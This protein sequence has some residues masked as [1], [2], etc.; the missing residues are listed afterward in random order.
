[1][2]ICILGMKGNFNKNLGQGVQIYNYQIWNN[3]KHKLKPPSHI[4][5]AELGF[6]NTLTIRKITFTLAQA[7]HNFSKYD[8][9]H[10]PSPIMFNPPGRGQ[11]VTTLHELFLLEKNHPLRNYGKPNIK[12]HNPLTEFIGESI[13]NQI[14]GSDYLLPNS[15][16]TFS[17]AAALGYPKD[18]MIIVNHAIDDKFIKCK[19]NKT[20]PTK[21][22]VGYLGAMHDRKNVQFAIKSF[23]LFN[24]NSAVFQIWGNIKPEHT[25]LLQ[26]ASTDSRIE[27]KGFA[28][29]SIKTNIYSNFDVFIFPSLYEG[30]GIEL[31]EAQ[32]LGIPV[33]I[34]KKSKI[35]KETRKYCFEA[36]DEEHAAHLIDEI[37]KNGYPETKRKVAMAYARSFTW[38]KCAKETLNA[39]KKIISNN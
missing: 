2:D 38:E 30:F 17:E 25:Q 13:L 6:G 31:L 10:I 8:L 12:I 11:K 26:L 28:P 39:Y 37:M 32:A 1:M 24:K 34:Y 18:R 9:V 27:F 22:T 35:P 20:N 19:V 23:M 21:F 5:K 33:I 29:E 16:Q 4:Y 3:L 7:M 36:K 14:M 15:T